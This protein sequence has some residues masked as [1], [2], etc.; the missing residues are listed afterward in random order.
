M[1]T[2]TVSRLRKNCREMLQWVA[3]GEEVEL[4]YRGKVVAKIVPPESQRPMAVD[5]STSAALSRQ[6]SGKTLTAEQSAA[7]RAESGSSIELR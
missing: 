7:I 4:T 1:K 6:R 3:K 2:A 5:W